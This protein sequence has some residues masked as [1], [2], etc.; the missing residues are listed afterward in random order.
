[1]SLILSS[2]RLKKI[3]WYSL[4][5]MRKQKSSSGAANYP[6]QSTY[7]GVPI[8]KELCKDPISHDE[9]T[10]TQTHCECGY[11]VKEATFV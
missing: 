4:N 5:L 3:R 10:R 9:V 8:W 6:Q 2:N 11:K 7:N 1:M